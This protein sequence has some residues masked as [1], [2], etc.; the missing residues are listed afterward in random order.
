VRAGLSQGLLLVVFQM[1]PAAAFL[2][3]VAPL[4]AAA[5]LRLAWGYAYAVVPL[6]AAAALF[7]ALATASLG[8]AASRLTPASPPAD[9]IDPAAA[10]RLRAFPAVNAVAVF[11]AGLLAY[12]ICAWA[13]PAGVAAN[14]LAVGAAAAL[15]S[16]VA[17]YV[18]AERFLVPI[19]AYLAA[20]RV[21]LRK[22]LFV[23]V[24]GKAAIAG[25]CGAASIIVLANGAAVTAGAWGWGHWLA[26]V[27][28][29]AATAGIA[30]FVVGRATGPLNNVARAS[31][32]TYY[33]GDEIENLTAACRNFLE[34]SRGFDAAIRKATEEL[35]QQAGRVRESLT[36]QASIASEQASAISETSVTMKELA[37]TVKQTATRA[38][39]ISGRVDS[40]VKLVKDAEDQ[41]LTNAERIDRLAV[42]SQNAAR[43]AVALNESARRMDEVVALVNDLAEQSTVLALNAAIEAAKAGEFGRGFSAVAREVK[44]LAGSSKEG[45]EEIRR[46]LHEIRGST[47]KTVAS[48]R[49]SA[50]QSD[51]LRGG[52]ARAK[53]LVA[54]I[55]PLVEEIGRMS[56][57]IAASARQ[58]SLGLEQV[59]TAVDNINDAAA[60]ALDQAKAVRS[61][62]ESIAAIS[63]RLAE[64]AEV[65]RWWKKP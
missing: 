43:L 41:I 48:A 59:T 12:V 8:R 53:V 16:A 15:L 46:V 27:V 62:V 30:S 61:A 2:F 19:F 49:E 40:S 44:N 35:G 38:E 13:V 32:I 22:R 1:I 65:P 9:T 31:F 55:V 42:E 64:E 10:R 60:E 24:Q 25:A 4:D 6:A 37:G 54:E 7:A 45:T 51:I 18:A 14:V 21:Y 56:K 23:P 50:E 52:A 34:E 39:E 29:I 63:S 57:Q 26:A 47:V 28:V 11:I 20:K 58:Q 33:V 36:E 3:L 5:R 17:S